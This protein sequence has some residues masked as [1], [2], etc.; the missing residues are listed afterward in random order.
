MSILQWNVNGVKRHHIELELLMRD[1]NYFCLCLQETHLRPGELFSLSGFQPYRCD[2]NSIIGRSKGGVAIFVHESVSATRVPLTTSLQAVAVKLHHR[3]VITVCNLYLPNQSWSSDNLQDLVRQLPR[4]CILLGDFN[5]H[6]TLWGSS[7]SDAAGRRVEDVMDRSDFVLLNDG[8][9]TYLNSISANTSAIDLSFC[10]PLLAPLIKWNTHDGLYSDHFPIKLNFGW[11]VPTYTTPRWLLQMAD[12]D[13]YT[14]L[15]NLPNV[16]Q[17]LSVS[18]NAAKITSAIQE[19]GNATIP[20]SKGKLRRRRVSWWCQPVAEAVR[21]CNSALRRFVRNM[22]IENMLNFKR[23]RAL[24]RHAIAKAKAS[25]I[26]TQSRILQ[27]DTPI[28]T[29]WDT[30][31]KMEGVGQLDLAPTTLYENGVAIHNP[32]DMPDVLGRHFAAISSRT[33]YTPAFLAS[34][35][36][37]ETN[38]LQRIAHCDMSADTADYNA[39]FTLPELERA[40]RTCGNTAPGADGIPYA[41]LLHLP[42]N[43]KISVLQ[44]FN[45]VWAK[46]E[47]PS[48]WREAIITAILKPG[49]PPFE[50]DSLRPIALMCCLPK[51]LEKMCNYR[52]VWLIEKLKIVDPRQSA[53]RPGRSTMDN[54]THFEHQIQ[55]AFVS[56][57]HTIAVLFDIEKAYD[58]TWRGGILQ[59]L[60]DGGVNGRMIKFIA[61]FLSPRFFRVRLNNHISDL[62]TQETGIAQGS[63]LS[64]TLFAVAINCLFNGLPPEVSGSLYVDDFSLYASGPNIDAIAMILQQAINVT[65]ANAR[66]RGFQFSASKTQ[67]IH[68]CRNHAPHADPVLQLD[69]HTITFSP[70]VKLLGLHFDRQ[71]RWTNHFQY[72]LAR[73][74]QGLNLMRC[75]AGVTWGAHRT[76]LLR[77]YNILILSRIDYGSIVYG[78]ARP[79]ALLPLDIIQ[80]TALRIATGAYCT[81]PIESLQVDTGFAPLHLRRLRHLFQY[82]ARVVATES[83]PNHLYWQSSHASH[84]AFTRRPSATRP[85][86]FRFHQ[87][88]RATHTQ[89]PLV[90]PQVNAEMAP[91]LYN[92]PKVCYDCVPKKKSNELPHSLRNSFASLLTKYPSECVYYTDGS[93]SPC[94]VGA[95]VY[96]SSFSKAVTLSP[97]ASIFTAECA[98]INLAL[99]QIYTSS[100]AGH[101]IIASD[102]LSVLQAFEDIFTKHE[103][104]RKAQCLLR[105]LPFGYIT[106]AWVPA[107]VDIHGNEQAD[108]LA[109]QAATLTAPCTPIP[110]G[111]CRQALRV[112]LETSWQRDWDRSNSLLHTIT[113]SVKH[114][115]PLHGTRRTFSVLTRL[116]LGA[117]R[118]TDE[119]RLTGNPQPVCQQCSNDLTIQHILQD[120]PGYQDTRDAVGLPTTIR[121]MFDSTDGCRA[122]LR[123]LS[124]Q[125]LFQL[126]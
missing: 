17:N 58:K 36:A 48:M 97:S 37:A 19:A 47:F 92:P 24:V 95:A 63:S 25:A 91:W 10:S 94:G 13:T 69:G 6:N 74:K 61:E 23:H 119:Y 51:L 49:K 33:S 32:K 115:L 68:F 87:Y 59:T 40:L 39:D 73:C 18:E 2:D 34:A 93:K 100:S 12:W 41:F 120:C 4:P 122:V 77:F 62:Y 113:P 44:L 46:G 35:T 56:H 20:R 125:K 111:D 31:R 27:P 107:H 52:L 29:V 98:A 75:L 80:N 16:N 118:L 8:S 83:H 28:A 103:L 14:A 89:L 126:I 117:T 11:H 78:S 54:L 70:V 99:E 121:N 106:L 102:S 15:A 65:S 53:F 110:L 84:D 5:A 72:L 90:I 50:P 108:R 43:S 116:R 67:A 22:T 66:A 81:T 85:A 60:L 42:P 38:I 101:A 1:V 79:S 82:G 30:L 86:A 45:Y 112:A 114:E 64:V 71:L 3:K 55:C 88:L 104:L 9:G 26:E 76:I 7:H 105:R 123:F 124:A 57:H 21:A 109:R 96:S